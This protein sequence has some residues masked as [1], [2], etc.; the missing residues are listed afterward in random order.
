ML[1]Y[2]RLWACAKKRGVS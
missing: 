1:V 2:L